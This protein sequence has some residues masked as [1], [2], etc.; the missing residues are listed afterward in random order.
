MR[1]PLPSLRL[2]PL[3]RKKLLRFRQIRRGYVSFLILCGLIALSVAAELLVNSRALVVRYQDRWYF[4][5]YGAIHTGR[6]FG[7]AYDYEVNYRDLKAQFAGTDNWVL[8]P[9]IPYSAV[10]N[11][12]RTGPRDTS[13]APT[14]STA[15]SSRACSTASATPWSS[16][17]ASLSSPI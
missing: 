12:Y 16:P 8:L 1:L 14:R 4:P 5:T 2:N 7:M 10:E 9:P 15:T 17:G 3:T 6:D 11:C 13:L